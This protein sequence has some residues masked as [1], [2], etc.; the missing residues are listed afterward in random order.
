[1]K[2][3]RKREYGKVY[4]FGA[5]SYTMFFFTLDLAQKYVT[6]YSIFHIKFDSK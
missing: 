1:M 6:N 4:S 2:Y 5:S 3:Q